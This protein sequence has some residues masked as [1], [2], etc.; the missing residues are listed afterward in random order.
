MLILSVL[1]LL[2]YAWAWLAIRKIINISPQSVTGLSKKFSGFLQLLVGLA[3]FLHGYLLYNW[4]DSSSGQNL[5]WPNLLSQI[6]WQMGVI[7]WITN[8]Y[9]F[10]R[11]LFKHPSFILLLRYARSGVT[12][13][14]RDSCFRRNDG[15]SKL[16]RLVLE[17]N[18]GFRKKSSV[19]NSTRAYG[20]DRVLFIL[21]IPLAMLSI[22]IGYTARIFDLSGNLN[23]EVLLSGKTIW[24]ILCALLVVS[25]LAVS[26]L[27]A[28]LMAYQSRCLKSA[29]V[30][31]LVNALPP[32]EIMEK[33]LFRSLTAGFL[34]LTLLII[35]SWLS[36]PL[37]MNLGWQKLTLT[38]I[39]WGIFSGLLLG[40]YYWGWRGRQA[41]YGTLSGTSLLFF[42]M[43]LSLLVK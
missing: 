29:K 40:R 17:Q 11:L 43:L 18:T 42:L 15:S 22:V 26:G 9:P 3:L 33:K 16:A 5:A 38:L 21:V 8:L 4:I 31:K 1:T 37:H 36:L 20:E 27:R 34:I 32:L 7:I 25:V 28:M 24:H 30:N 14:G 2:S 12:Q 35:T 19:K 13:E 41:L 10:I 23:A 6:F 39:N